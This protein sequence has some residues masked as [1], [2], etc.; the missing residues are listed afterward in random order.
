MK[1]IIILS[2]AKY[3][4]RFG[5]RQL[6]GALQADEITARFPH[7]LLCANNKPPPPVGTPVSS[8]LSDQLTPTRQHQSVHAPVFYQIAANRSTTQGNPG[9]DENPFVVT[10]FGKRS[11]QHAYAQH[12]LMKIQPLKDYEE[13]AKSGSGIRQV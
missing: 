4:K 5:L 11:V 10:L 7:E 3:A 6:S 9:S 2:F 8:R 13:R 1:F 12:V